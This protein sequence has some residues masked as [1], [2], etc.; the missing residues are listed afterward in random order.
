MFASRGILAFVVG[1][2]VAVTLPIL[3][4]GCN[5]GTVEVDKSASYTPDALAD[6]LVLRFRALSGTARTASY[7]GS[8]A[9]SKSTKGA[10][11]R[12]VSKKSVTRATKKKGA[13]T[14]DD[15]LEDIDSKIDLVP[16]TPHVATKQQMLDKLSRDPSLRDTEKK[17]LSE[18]VGRLGD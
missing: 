13:T 9:R 14:I 8:A 16:G 4:A 12:A 2:G 5:S 7:Q 1:A 11:A 10:P 18:L 17:E 6:E 15:V 3:G